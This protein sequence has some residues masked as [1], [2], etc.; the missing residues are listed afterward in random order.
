MA[1][2]GNGRTGQGIAEGQKRPQAHAVYGPV[3]AKDDPF[4]QMFDPADL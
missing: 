2:K 1:I 3:P 4:E